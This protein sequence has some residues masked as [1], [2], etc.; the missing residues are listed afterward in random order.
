MA[1]DEPKNGV[2]RCS[3]CGKPET[4]VHKLIE[5]PG[6]FICDECINQCSTGGHGENTSGRKHL[7]GCAGRYYCQRVRNTDTSNGCVW[8]NYRGSG[9]SGPS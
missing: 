3:F 9:G 6:V 2:A 7:P 4:L 5:G 1:H 8:G